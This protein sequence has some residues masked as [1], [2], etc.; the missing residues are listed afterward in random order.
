M[1]GSLILWL[2]AYLAVGVGVM[3]LIHFF[4][5]EFDF[6]G[7]PEGFIFGCVVAWPVIVMFALY[8]NLR[9]LLP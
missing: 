3:W 1:I 2:V 6:E 8:Y 7:E 9:K 5:R 4:D